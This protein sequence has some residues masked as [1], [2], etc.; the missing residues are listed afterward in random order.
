MFGDYRYVPGLPIGKQGDYLTDQLTGEALKV[1]D[2]LKDRPFYLY[3]AYYTRL[4]A[5]ATT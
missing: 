2:S 5:H 3:M 4:T 1:I